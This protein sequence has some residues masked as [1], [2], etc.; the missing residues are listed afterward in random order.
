MT[1]ATIADDQIDP[2]DPCMIYNDARELLRQ[3]ALINHAINEARSLEHRLGLST[4]NSRKLGT[5]TS[6]ALR[7][8]MDIT[9]AGNSATVP[10][11]VVVEAPQDRAAVQTQELNASSAEELP[12]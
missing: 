4:R 9:S 12:T 6:R 11:A 7:Q 10:R 8:W 5:S 1:A 3:L 2:T